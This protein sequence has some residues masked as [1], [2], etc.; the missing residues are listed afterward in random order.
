MANIRSP[1]PFQHTDLADEIKVEDTNPKSRSFTEPL[2]VK[3][4][5]AVDPEAVD[6]LGSQELAG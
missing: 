2:P 4:P 3:I 6:H 5:N 1:E